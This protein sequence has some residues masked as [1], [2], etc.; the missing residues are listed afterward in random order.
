MT[1]VSDAMSRAFTTVAADATVREASALARAAGAG[2]LLVMDADNL[3]GVVCCDCDLTGAGPDDAVAD[4]MTVP[5]FTVRPDAT[6]EEA[7]LTMRDCRVGCLPVAS[8]GLL[9][10]VLT[11]DALDRVPGNRPRSR[12]T[13]HGRP[14]H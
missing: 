5:V 12:C 14:L 6:L 2:H 10:G 7:A 8:G 9:L 1:L 3:V 13:C 4:R 11:G